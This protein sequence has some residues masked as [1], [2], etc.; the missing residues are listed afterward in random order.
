MDGRELTVPPAAAG[1]GPPGQPRRSGAVGHLG[2]RL[3][4]MAEQM[5]AE[6]GDNVLDVLLQLLEVCWQWSSMWQSRSRK[7]LTLSISS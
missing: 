3:R 5:L 6:S 4:P 2:Q 1:G 7:C